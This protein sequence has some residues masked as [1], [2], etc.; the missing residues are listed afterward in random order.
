MNKKVFMVIVLA[1]MFSMCVSD[2]VAQRVV[3]A[4]R[5]EVVNNQNGSRSFWLMLD[6]VRIQVS[7]VVAK[8]VEPEPTAFCVV[9]TGGEKFLFKRAALEAPREQYVFEVAH[10][11]Q[12]QGE[13][14]LVTMTNGYS[15]TD[16]DIAWLAVQPGQHVQVS[17]Y[18]GVEFE[19][20]V[21]KTVSRET[22][23]SEGVDVAALSAPAKSEIPQLLEE[24]KAKKAKLMAT[25]AA[26][27]E[28]KASGPLTITFG[29]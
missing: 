5:L 18:I 13:G 16:P 24:S 12:M 6:T 19:L 21:F 23:L 28:K 15:F 10:A 20:M 3:D 4:R 2:A 27:A 7:D 26:P 9:E 17:R 14:V 22:Q 11:P 8:I 29:N 1:T 25:T